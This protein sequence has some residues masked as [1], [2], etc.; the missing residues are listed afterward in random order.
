MVLAFPPVVV[1][2]PPQ[3]GVLERVDVAVA[4]LEALA[5]AGALA[6]ALVLVALA[7]QRV[8]APPLALLVAPLVVARRLGRVRPLAVLS[9]NISI[10][11]QQR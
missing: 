5:L 6:A 7:L 1:P 3:R 9:R 8:V 11:F 10:Y 2:L 4:A